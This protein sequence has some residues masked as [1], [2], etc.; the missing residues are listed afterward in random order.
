MSCFRLS[1]FA[2]A[3]PLTQR[4]SFATVLGLAGL[5]LGV[6]A[7]SEAPKAGDCERLLMHLVEVEVSASSAAK[8]KQAEHKVELADGAR[9]SFVERCNNELKAKQVTCAL[10]AKSSEELDACDG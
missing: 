6:S 1:S 2:L 10:E 9:A 8:D 7:C 3:K 5:S 4:I